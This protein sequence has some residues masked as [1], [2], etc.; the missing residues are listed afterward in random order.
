MGCEVHIYDSVGTF[1]SKL[2][3]YCLEDSAAATSLAGIEWYGHPLWY[4]G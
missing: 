3:L 1:V 4:C 2:A